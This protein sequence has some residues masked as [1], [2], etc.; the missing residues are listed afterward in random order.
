MGRRIDYSSFVTAIRADGGYR[1]EATVTE[2]TLEHW[3]YL[4]DMPTD[5]AVCAVEAFLS[6]FEGD[7]Q[8]IYEPAGFWHVG[9]FAKFFFEEELSVAFGAHHDTFFRLFR[10]GERDKHV[11]ILAPRGS[12][13]STCVGRIYPLHCMF[14]HSTY[15]RLCLPTDDFI[16]IISYS[17]MQAKDHVVAIRDKIEND[18]R[19]MHLEGSSEWGSTSL[20]TAQG[21]WLSALSVGKSLRGVLKGQYRPTL[22]VK[23]DV[24][25]TDTVRNPEMREKALT[26]HDSNLLPAGVAGY[27]NFISIDTLKHPE[28]LASILRTRPSV[29]TTHLRAIPSPAD[30]RH[31]TAGERW[32]EW[33]KL[34]CDMSAD[35][36][37]REARAQEYY[38][39]HKGEMMDGVVELWPERLS[40]L[41][42]QKYVA[43]RGYPFV[44]QEFQNDISSSDEFIFDMERASRFEETRQGFV[45]DDGVLIEWREMA[46]ATVF[47]DWAGT[48][49]DSKN[50][51]YACV[52]CVVWV[53]QRGRT[54]M[55][56]SHLAS[57][58]AYVYD[59]W[60]SRGTGATQY[61]ALLDL[62]DAV[63]GKLLANVSSHE[64]K[65]HVVQEGFIDTTGFVKPGALH[66]F[67]S[68]L[69]ER[70]FKDVTLQFLSRAGAEEKH[71]RIRLLQAPF[72]NHWLHFNKVLPAE[73][74]RQLSLFPTA[75]FDDGPDALEG[76]VNAK[77]RIEKM[78][79]AS[80]VIA[81][82]AEDRAIQ[83]AARQRRRI[84]V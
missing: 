69:R 52:V 56:V 28:S 66:N 1:K 72:D 48:R 77:F 43:E 2:Q 79:P 36:T 44:M 15:R 68:V 30:L 7:P 75:E 63:R 49:S 76:A 25:A 81:G 6:T 23:D 55:K 54:D 82:S 45:R 64:P 35:D 12:G 53:P 47:L 16:L 40:Y 33:T 61:T 9:V 84:R 60:I 67:E 34:Y 8:T 50:N 80:S 14:Y 74:E 29:E 31:P 21:V 51:C 13:K 83:N 24:D 70:S 22:I 11:N 78:R 3:R 58:H 17:F 5:E 71:T 57:C 73:F 10:R 20:R 39:A 18:T 65:F 42:I 38:E 27:S 37:V 4:Q 26:W 19:F 41:Q 32:D 46:G 62:H 59:A